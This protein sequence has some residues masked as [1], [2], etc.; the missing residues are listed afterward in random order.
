MRDSYSNFAAMHIVNTR[1]GTLFLADTAINAHMTD[2]A[3]YDIARLAR[4]SVAYFA[5]EPVMA[6]VSSSNF[7]SSSEREATMVARV[8]SRL[9]QEF[10]ELPVD[11][12]MQLQNALNTKL[13][14]A[15]FPFTRLN[16]REVNTLIFPNLTA[17]HS[18]Y[19]LLLEMGIGDAI[20]P[21]QIGLNK[22]VHFVNVDSPVR[23]ILNVVA[24][25]V[26]DAHANV[27][28]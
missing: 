17:A 22:P 6:M 16:G 21:I 25:A 2:E 7:G 15:N 28:R 10:P 26:V 20:G 8:V 9:Q 13:R 23:D 24:V 27:C 18:A 4:R 14:D 19:R 11:G 12:E 5:H 3:L 1:R